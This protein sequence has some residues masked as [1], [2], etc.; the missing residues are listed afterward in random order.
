MKNLCCKN[1][2]VETLVKL[3]VS[4]ILQEKVVVE[5][6]QLYED[7]DKNYLPLIVKV[8]EFLLGNYCMEYELDVFEG[9]KKDEPDLTLIDFLIGDIAEEIYIHFGRKGIT[10]DILYVTL[11]PEEKNL[12]SS[13]ISICR[14][15][16]FG[17]MEHVI[18]KSGFL[19]E[20]LE[21]ATMCNIRTL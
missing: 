17:Y 15:C 16:G 2:S 7:L 11:S 6:L 9:L 8:K 13:F 3:L 18:L 10:D 21:M 5:E 4:K 1:C 20:F 14:E 12:C 19:H